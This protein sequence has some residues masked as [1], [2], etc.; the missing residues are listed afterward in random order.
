MLNSQARTSKLEKNQQ[1]KKE[2]DE[3]VSSLNLDLDEHSSHDSNI[4]PYESNSMAIKHNLEK[5]QSMKRKSDGGLYTFRKIDKKCDSINFKKE[6][7][8]DL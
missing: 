3:S 2:V 5:R 4:Q 7:N 8:D 6:S 1:N